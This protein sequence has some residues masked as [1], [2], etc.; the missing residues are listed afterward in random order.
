MLIKL[1][2]TYLDA[3]SSSVLFSQKSKVY[4]SHEN[5]AHSL[6]LPVKSHV[7]SWRNGP[8][9]F[10]EYYR[11]HCS[12]RHTYIILKMSGQHLRTY[13]T[14]QNLMLVYILYIINI[15]VFLPLSVRPSHH[16]VI[17]DGIKYLFIL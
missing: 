9:K 4:A 12:R 6:T 17:T 16:P 14:A 1:N 2:K 11:T 3:V 8:I 15:A 7:A 5:N 10:I 13:I